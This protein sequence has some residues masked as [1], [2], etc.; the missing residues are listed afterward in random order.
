MGQCYSQE[1]TSPKVISMTVSPR[2]IEGHSA[3]PLIQFAKQGSA[4]SITSAGAQPKT[5][6]TQGGPREETLRNLQQLQHLM[7]SREKIDD[8]VMQTLPTNFIIQFVS[9]ESPGLQQKAKDFN[10][11]MESA[12]QAAPEFHRAMH[13]VVKRAGLTPAA[14]ALHDG[15]KLCY[16]D[17]LYKTLTEAALKP[18]ERCRQKAKDDFGGDLSKVFD[19][20]RCSIVVNTEEQLIAV[21]KALMSLEVVRLKNRFKAP[22]WNGYRDALYNIRISDHICEVQLHLGAILQQTEESYGHYQL[23]RKFFAVTNDVYKRRMAML[24]KYFDCYSDSDVERVL[25]RLLASD[26][27]TMLQDMAEL[28][29]IMED[30]HLLKSVYDRL[31]RL[32]PKNS[33]YKDQLGSA[34]RR[35]GNF[36]DALSTFQECLAKQKATIGEKH[37]ETLRTMDKVALVLDDQGKHKEAA[38]V[39]QECL[40]DQKEHL[41][42]THADTLLTL[43]NL[44]LVLNKQANYKEAEGLYRECLEKRKE[45]LGDTH[46]GTLGTLHNLAGVLDSLGRYKEAETLFQDCLTKKQVA[47]GNSHPDTLRTVN[48]LAAVLDHQG[49]YKEAESLYKQCLAKKKAALGD[50]HPDTLRT[51]NNLAGVLDD[52]CKYKE[53][54]RLYKECFARKRETLGDAH[55]DTLRTLNNLAGVLDNQGKYKEAEGLFRDCYAM[56]KATLGDSHPGTLRTMNNLARV[57]DNRSKYSEAEAL[58]QECYAKKKARL[59]ES[60][61]DTLQALNSLAGVLF[62]AGK[63]HEAESRYMECLAQRNATLGDRHSDTVATQNNLERVKKARQ[64]RPR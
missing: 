10:A 34:L 37:P 62:R 9:H 46:P 28:A 4:A 12:T 15:K 23:F 5:T 53:A 31:A 48:S 27:E 13:R 54:E 49:K 60:H 16:G 43:N 63:L 61:R 21:A 47:L 1:D 22:L 24:E 17:T 41:G 14:F 7:K 20:V 26:D 11:L 42:D 51:L 3:G 25:L 19:L 29:V 56:K 40:A 38:A 6:S 30:S 52:Q 45:T 32:D 44:A 18:A 55:P 2:S 36:E 57:L 64:D 58:F 50:T 35:C 8:V 33:L 59:G 39:Y